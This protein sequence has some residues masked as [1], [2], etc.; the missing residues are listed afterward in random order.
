MSMTNDNG[1]T[2]RDK[3]P[4]LIAL[5][6]PCN[7]TKEFLE[8]LDEDIFIVSVAKYHSL[9]HTVDL[10]T[11]TKIW[12]ELDDIDSLSSSLQIIN[13]NHSNNTNNRKII[14]DAITQLRNSEMM[15]LV[16]YFQRLITN[17]YFT[18]A[19][20][21]L[22][23]VET[24]A[25]AL[26]QTAT[27]ILDTQLNFRMSDTIDVLMPQNLEKAQK[28]SL[29]EAK[30]SFYTVNKL[31]C[32]STKSAD[33]DFLKSAIK[34]SWTSKR[35]LRFIRWG[36]EVP[37]L[38]LEDLIRNNVQQFVVSGRYYTVSDLASSFK[39]WELFYSSAKL[40][41]LSHAD[42]AAHL[43]YQMDSHGL[44]QPIGHVKKLPPSESPTKS[45]S[46]SKWAAWS[47]NSCLLSRISSNKNF[48]M[49]ARIKLSDG[50]SEGKSDLQ[51]QMEA[52]I[53]ALEEKL[54]ETEA[55]VRSERL[56]A[57][58]ECEAADSKERQLA[59][60]TASQKNVR[61]NSS[62]QQMLERLRE[63]V[64]ALSRHNTNLLNEQQ[65]LETCSQT[66]RAHQQAVDV[67]SEE[68]SGLQSQLADLEAVNASKV[69]ELIELKLAVCELNDK[70]DR[71]KNAARRLMAASGKGSNNKV[72][73]ESIGS[74]SSISQLSDEKRGGGTSEVGQDDITGLLNFKL[75]LGSGLAS[76]PEMGRRIA[77]RF[78]RSATVSSVDS[79]EY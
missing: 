43:G 66:V 25:E 29:K 10:A 16:L 74:M 57:D 56:A 45:P 70:V 63:E 67:L 32:C 72:K 19:I 78:E 15:F 26:I 14:L 48:L 73:T 38:S 6:P 37:R 8:S 24:H 18:M 58:R 62:N 79:Y 47:S 12:T 36:R 77:V 61:N 44:V 33:M 52:K 53:A 17:E 68:V 39:S 3:G 75:G 7:G 31:I 22:I 64:A 41:K 49:A 50:S 30:A 69:Q 60:E 40:G 28:M 35:M 5:I 13:G 65:Q 21:R 2:D 59:K 76:K 51:L 55:V 34:Y 27:N 23:S 42:I 9:Y 1:V 54:L 20:R 11:T 4:I 71:T 46:P